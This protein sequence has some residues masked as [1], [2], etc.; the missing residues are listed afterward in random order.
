MASYVSTAGIEPLC[1]LYDVRRAVPKDAGDFVWT[2]VPF[3]KDLGHGHRVLSADDTLI[4]VPWLHAVYEQALPFV[5]SWFPTA[6]TGRVLDETVRLSY[7]SIGSDVAVHS[8]P[9]LVVGLLVIDDHFRGGDL[10]FRSDDDGPLT[11]EIPKW[12]L[13]VF[14]ASVPHAVTW[15][16]YGTRITATMRYALDGEEGSGARL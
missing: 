10:V 6:R 4:H 9:D 7:M 2:A 3:T 1:H 12:R 16:T 13:A 15:V 5:R 14:D 11:V 8:E